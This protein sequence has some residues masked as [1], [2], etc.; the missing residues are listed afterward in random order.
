MGSDP[1]GAKWVRPLLVFL[2]SVF[3]F[4]AAPVFAADEQI[5]S[6]ARAAAAYNERNLDAALR[7]AK[8]AVAEEPGHVDALFLLG[9]LYYLRQEMSKA[10]E[11]WK[12][13]LQLAPGRKDV[14]EA[15][16]RLDREAGVEKNLT[17]GD[18]HPFV[19][20][21]AEGQVPVDTSSLREML[22]DAYRKIGQQFNYFPD[23]AIP[24]LL[25]SD[26]DFQ[27]IKSLSHPVG[28]L[29]DGKIR[30]PLKVGSLSGDRLQAILWHEYTHAVVHD[31]SRGGCPIWLQEGL[32]QTQESRVAAVEVDRVQTALEEGKLPAWD[33][34]WSES[35]YDEASMSLN[36][37]T[38]FSIAQYLVR[39]WSWREMTQLLERL[40]QGY[41]MRD[42]LRAQ[43]RTDPAV[44]EKEWRAWLRRNL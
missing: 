9:Q 42:A 6:Y 31:L 43:Y 18:I 36:Y 44:I 39:R 22:R 35:S 11:S 21:F 3:L 17:R 12:R 29:Y 15:L 26:A 34:L 2:F 37:Q 28:G 4:A 33:P 30:L 32:A 7:Y 27:K 16:E 10:E 13:A 14:K 24:V 38:S 40:G 23:H 19:L 1:F 25:Y 41:P 8:E 20:R 5:S